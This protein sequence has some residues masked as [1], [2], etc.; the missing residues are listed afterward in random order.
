[1]RR[2]RIGSSTDRSRGNRDASAGQLSEG[3]LPGG[4]KECEQRI[5]RDHSGTEHFHA[6][7]PRE[8]LPH[9]AA[10]DTDQHSP[11]GERERDQQSGREQN[12]K[13]ALR[14]AQELDD[15]A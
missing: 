4:C 10:G 11:P 1:M 9:D 3:G 2:S 7:A 8:A 13:L 14:A 12:A 6:F 15:R 5:A